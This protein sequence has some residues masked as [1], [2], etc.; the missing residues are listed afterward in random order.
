MTKHTFKWESADLID[1]ST[2][3][4]VLKCG[5]VVESP[6]DVGAIVYAMLNDAAKGD[7]PADVIT[8]Y[9]VAL[10]KL[11]AMSYSEDYS[12][13]LSA[14]FIIDTL[15]GCGA[16]IPGALEIIKYLEGLLEALEYHFGNRAE[17]LAELKLIADHASDELGRDIVRFMPTA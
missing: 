6:A 4:M 1:S 3:E 15:N 9:H 14:S 8:K 11:N 13:E 16:G 12:F 10:K 7:A 5:D 2:G 17:A